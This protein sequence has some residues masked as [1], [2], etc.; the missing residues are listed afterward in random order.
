MVSK[1]PFAV[2]SLSAALAYHSLGWS[3]IPIAAGKKIPALK[4]KPFQTRRADE[5]QIRDWYDKRNDLGLAVVL[6]K[7][8]GGLTCRDFDDEAAYHA[9]AAQNSDL[10]KTLPTAR[11]GRGFHVYFVSDFDHTEKLGDGELRGKGA[12]VMLP[13]SKHPSGVQYRWIIP[14]T[15][16]IPRLDFRQF[17]GRQPTERQSHVMASVS[18]SLRLSVSPSLRVSVSPCLRVSGS[19]SLWFSG[20]L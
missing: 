6:G 11:T 10:A 15:A 20:S 17:Q 14:P 19:P 13:P 18:P 7:V 4:W 1:D 2:D 9:W 12:I 8:S 16:N 5:Q 3:I